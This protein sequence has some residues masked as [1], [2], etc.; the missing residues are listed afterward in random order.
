MTTTED[1]YQAILQ[2]VAARGRVSI[3]ELTRQ[4]RVS[5]MTIRRDLAALDAEGAVRRVRGGALPVASGSY[6]PPFAARAKLN[7]AAKRD[8]ALLASKL[9]SDGETV[10]LDGGTTGAAIAQELMGRD[11]TVCTPSLRV[12]DVLSGS[13]TVRLMIPGGIVRPGERT[14]I[15]PP[16]LRIFEDHQFDV[17]VMTVSGLHITAGM[18]EWNLDDAAVKRAALAAANRCIVA[19]DATKFGK[20]AFGRICQVDQTDV[21]ITDAAL[22]AG[23]RTAFTAADVELGIA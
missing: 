10:I 18:T 12:A 11:I 9:I 20:T 4:L 13:S 23:Q 5:E 19:C 7:S 8:I 6:E 15:G 1:R 3:T 14:L 2:L 17:Y 21:I 16:A 22:P